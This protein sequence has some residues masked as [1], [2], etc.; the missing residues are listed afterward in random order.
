MIKILREEL[1][2]RK[3][4]ANLAE[5]KTN[6][7]MG[8]LMQMKDKEDNY[9]EDDTVLQ[10]TLSTIHIGYTSITDTVGWA[11][12]FVAKSPEVYQKLRV[13]NIYL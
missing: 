1:E 10:N 2:K 7:L 3:A 5:V 13:C 9:L 4:D 11:L 8:R 12:Y 6:D